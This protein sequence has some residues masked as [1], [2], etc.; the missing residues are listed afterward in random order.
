MSFCLRVIFHFLKTFIFGDLG[1][2]LGPNWAKTFRAAY[3]A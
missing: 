2:I 3:R 1:I